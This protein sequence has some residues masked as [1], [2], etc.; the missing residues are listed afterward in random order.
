MKILIFWTWC[1]PQSLFGLIGFVLYKMIG[2]VEATKDYK[3]V[4]VTFIKAPPLKGWS[5]FS[6]GQ[7]IFLHSR[8]LK[9]ENKESYEWL[10]RHEYGHT[11]QNFLLGPLYLIIVG[12]SSSLLFLY[13]RKNPDCRSKYHTIFPE[14][15]ANKLA[16]LENPPQKLMDFKMKD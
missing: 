10:I 3:G 8:Y 15:W 6:S 9:P 16:G 5:G 14:S 11:L 4:L 13:T 12:I 1:L 7:F 2:K